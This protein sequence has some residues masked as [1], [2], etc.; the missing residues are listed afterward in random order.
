MLLSRLEQACWAAKGGSGLA[1]AAAEVVARASQL[2]GVVDGLAPLAPTDMF[3][4]QRAMEKPQVCKPTQT[5]VY[6]FLRILY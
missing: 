2:P 4:P 6:T 5:T 1:A 3:L